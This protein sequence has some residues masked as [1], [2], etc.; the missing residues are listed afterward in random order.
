MTSSP[1]N[2]ALSIAKVASFTLLESSSYYDL[3]HTSLNTYAD[4]I[5]MS[6][7]LSLL[8]VVV[9]PKFCRPSLHVHAVPHDLSLIV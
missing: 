9:S 4:T 3:D 8:I 5:S 6:P 7:E 2:N 1:R